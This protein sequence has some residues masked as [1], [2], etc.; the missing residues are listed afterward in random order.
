MKFYLNTNCLLFDCY[1]ALSRN[2]ALYLPPHFLSLLLALSCD[3]DVSVWLVNLLLSE[4]LC[5]RFSALLSVSLSPLYIA[6]FMC[7]FRQSSLSLSFPPYFLFLTHIS[8]TC[9]AQYRS[10]G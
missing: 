4:S 9:G 6:V 10:C 1:T 2:L 8:T 5:L 3:V 7:F